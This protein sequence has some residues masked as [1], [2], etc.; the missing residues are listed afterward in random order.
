[1][2]FY[3]KFNMRLDNETIT[4]T[5]VLK[6][7]WGGCVIFENNVLAGRRFIHQW[8]IPFID[9]EFKEY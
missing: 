6:P 8:K 5:Q 2:T 9:E 1:M 4:F 7:T 3:N